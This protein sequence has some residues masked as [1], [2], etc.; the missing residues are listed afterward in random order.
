M[1]N[2]LENINQTFVEQIQAGINCINYEKF[3]ILAIHK[4]KNSNSFVQYISLNDDCKY[5]LCTCSDRALRLYFFDFY[6]IKSNYN[7]S[8][9][10]KT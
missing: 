8:K 7:Q 6:A 4:F 5:L 9:N 2:S 3:E 1:L 10:S